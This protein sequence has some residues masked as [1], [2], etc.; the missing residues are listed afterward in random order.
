MGPANRK[1][2]RL[3]AIQSY[4]QKDPELLR[5]GQYKGTEKAFAGFKR[6]LEKLDLIE[7][8]SVILLLLN[9]TIL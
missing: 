4:D 7:R 9:E 6:F 3:F 1:I 8:R 2:L 5:T